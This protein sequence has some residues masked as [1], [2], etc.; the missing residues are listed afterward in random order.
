MMALMMMWITLQLL[1][2]LI[3]LIRIQME[4]VMLVIQMMMVM[5]FLMPQTHFR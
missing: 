1:L 4:K 2:T 3:S 5:E